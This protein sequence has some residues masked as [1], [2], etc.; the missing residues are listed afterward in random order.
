MDR[1]VLDVG[2]AIE[3]RPCAV[4]AA[5]GAISKEDGVGLVHSDS[6]GVGTVKVPSTKGRAE[7]SQ[8]IWSERAGG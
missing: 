1:I 8:L 4:T 3:V 2:L 6:E 5:I 7:L